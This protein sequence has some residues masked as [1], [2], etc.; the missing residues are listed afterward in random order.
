MTKCCKCRMENVPM[1]G[2]IGRFPSFHIC[3]KCFDKW[4]KFLDPYRPQLNS[5][6]GTPEFYKIWEKAFQKFLGKTQKERVDFT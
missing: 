4:H 6:S 2:M 1:Y 3:Q 5:A